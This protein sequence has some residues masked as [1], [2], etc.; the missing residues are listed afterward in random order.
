LTLWRARTAGLALA[1]GRSVRFGGE[2]AVA[3][4][5]GTPL[6][7][8]SLDRL[9]EACA[10]VAISAPEASLAALLAAGWG[11]PVI[12][13]PQDSPRGPLT[14]VCAGLDWARAHGFERL[15][16]LPCDLPFAPAELF[17][18]LGD[19][20][21]DGDGGAVARTADGLQS[22]CL[23]LRTKVQPDLAAI[24]AGGCHPS[25]HEWLA[26]AGVREVGFDDAS[27]FANVNTPEDLKRAQVRA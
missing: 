25:V 4:L 18:R 21:Q 1:G 20:L 7:R 2:K 27:G 3:T 9:D 12:A 22:L 17:D 11:V 13:D 24:L 19:A 15:A 8:L 23:V 14:G 5:K 6:L 10:T 16:V 26:G